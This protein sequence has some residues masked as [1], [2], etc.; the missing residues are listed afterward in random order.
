LSVTY[1]SD[2]NTWQW[3]SLFVRNKPT[4]SSEKALRYD[5]DLTGSVAK[6]SLV[7]SMKKLGAKTNWIGNKTDCDSE[8]SWLRQ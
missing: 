2:K 8:L 5:S 6:I 3:P 4:P 1:M 7:V